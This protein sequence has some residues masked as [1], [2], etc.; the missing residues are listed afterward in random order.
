[1]SRKVE[2]NPDVYHSN[3]SSLHV[4][5]RSSGC[6]QKLLKCFTLKINFLLPEANFPHTFNH[7]EI[8]SGVY[9]VFLL[10]FFG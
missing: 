8:H 4:K 1:M 5:S 6:Y 10:N 7:L 2:T 3:F 9:F